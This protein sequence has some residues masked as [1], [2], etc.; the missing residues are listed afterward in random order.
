MVSSVLATTAGP[1]V[2]R[3]AWPA[4]PSAVRLNL[5]AFQTRS[6]LQTLRQQQ[7][8]GALFAT[9]ETL[10]GNGALEAVFRSL[11]ALMFD[12]ANIKPSVL[13]SRPGAGELLLSPE[14]VSCLAIALLVVVLALDTSST[15][16]T[17]AAAAAPTDSSSSGSSGSSSSGRRSS[18]TSRQQQQVPPY[19]TGG[20]SSSSNGGSSSSNGVQVDSLTPL[21]CSLF[22]VL[23]VSREAALQAAEFVKSMG[24]ATTRG[25][26]TW[27]TAYRTVIQHQVS[28]VEK[29]CWVD[30]G[31]GLLVSEF[32]SYWETAYRQ[33]SVSHSACH[34]S[35]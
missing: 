1:L 7:R 19:Q 4:A 5:Q 13:Q 35:D 32:V 11:M 30:P 24:I 15:A 27:V 10:P 8:F 21:S 22:G 12:V 31:A 34:A 16:A 28:C 3:A 14:F 33:H 29:T 6:Q 25:L 18:H 26:N 20:S 2:C 23:G 17:A 9:I